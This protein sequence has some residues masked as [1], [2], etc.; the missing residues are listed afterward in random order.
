MKPIKLATGDG[1]AEIVLNRPEILNA[2][3]LEMLTH[4]S[5][6]LDSCWKDERVKV[7]VLKGSGG[8]FSSGADLKQFLDFASGKG[9][10]MEYGLKLHFEVV[11]KMREIPKPIIAEVRG[12]AIGAG[13]G[14]VTASDYAIASENSVFSCGYI[15]IGLSP[16]TGTSFFIPRNCGLKRA[17][18]LMATGRTF[19][20]KEA[21]EYG[22]VTE[23][24]PEN[25]LEER[26][27]EVV[28]IL[29]SRP[30]VAI[31]NLKKLLNSTHSNRIDEHLG[32]ELN[33]AMISAMTR[34]FLEGV[35]AMLK[36]REP[37]FH[38]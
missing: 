12:Y 9:S 31:A 26:V 35:S 2:I 10:P 38:D 18:E 1:F 29:V 23:V 22:I 15:L 11:K 28:R 36:K 25:R 6:A 32:L 21:L 4:L 7:I 20:A 24:V 3:N 33:L 17:F 34:D 30:R 37:K 19:S 8:N 27:R 13:L 14:L 5:E 16:D